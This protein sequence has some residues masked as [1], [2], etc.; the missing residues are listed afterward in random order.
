MLI[1]TLRVACRV[2][3]PAF[4]FTPFH[5]FPPLHRVV[6]SCTRLADLRLASQFPKRTSQPQSF[7]TTAIRSLCRCSV[8]IPPMLWACLS[9][10]SRHAPNNSG[11]CTKTENQQRPIF[12]SVPCCKQ[13]AVLKTVSQLLNFVFHRPLFAVLP[14]F[15]ITHFNLQV[16]ARCT[17]T[18]FATRLA[19]RKPCPSIGLLPRCLCSRATGIQV[20]MPIGGLPPQEFLCSAVV[21][22]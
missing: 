12:L 10:S 4:T 17:E 14:L 11:F 7:D 9:R 6:R 13:T 8:P 22:T 21:G 18:D 19:L 20:P 2:S 15:Y 1:E 3:L 5:L 16:S